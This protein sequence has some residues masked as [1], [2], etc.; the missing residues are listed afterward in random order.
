MIVFHLQNSLVRGRAEFLTSAT[1][2]GLTQPAEFWRD[3]GI[4]RS[5]AS[6]LHLDLDAFF[7]AV[8]QRDK[9]SL[10]G[11]PVV[12]GGVG[13]RG[14]VATASYEARAFG[15]RSAM[16]TAEARRRCPHAAYLSGRFTAYRK[17]SRQVMALLYKLSP[18]V[19]QLSID[20]AYVDLG[21]ADV[22]VTDLVALRALGERLRAD[23]VR[24]TGGL[25]A[26]VGMGSSKFL[27]KVASELAKPD[28]LV[29]VEPGTE[30]DI[31][32]PLPVRAVPGVGPVT[33]EKL[34]RLGVQTVADLRQLTERE[35]V[36]EIG[37]AWG[38]T[39]RELAF[40]RD[41]REVST[42]REPKSVS[43]EHTFEHDVRERAQLVAVIDRDAAVVAE[44]VQKARLFARTVTIKVRLADFTTLSR[45]RT[46]AG[47]TD[48]AEAFARAGRELLSG[49]AIS[50]GVRLLGIGV[51]NFAEVGQEELFETDVF[52]DTAVEVAEVPAGS[53]VQEAARMWRPGV[54][55]EHATYG[56]GWVWGSGL[57]RVTVR[58]ETADSGPGPVKTFADS[59]P[60][61]ALVSDEDLGNGY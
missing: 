55:V 51:A 28:G 6:V 33:Y 12:V 42:Q 49:L 15:V 24:E 5:T 25:T 4:V 52:T 46:L 36:R 3:D 16:S 29:L 23:V 31:I 17:A 45:S 54:D 41:E 59:D 40:A 32:A 7:A 34:T 47:A 30:V 27:A 8:E 61:L 60:E 50:Q 9:P 48:R 13:G 39:L 44:R 11:K 20:E 57:G 21:A 19:E 22:D 35:L 38:P 2:A 37:A 1:C 26:S 56:R 53:G 18:Q 14:V 43:V 10:R 58:F